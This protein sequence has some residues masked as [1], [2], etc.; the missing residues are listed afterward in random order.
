LY[1]ALTVSGLW[2][3]SSQLVDDL[4]SVRKSLEPQYPAIRRLAQLRTMRKA[5]GL[6]A[7]AVIMIGLEKGIVPDHSRNLA[8]EAR[9]FYVAM[10]RAREKLYLLH[11]WRRG[12]DVTW[13][14]K[15][16]PGRRRSCFLNDIGRPSDEIHNPGAILSYA[17]SGLE[18]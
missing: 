2:K 17:M 4:F 10:T 12:A 16:V 15:N 1:T 9:L 6:E 8:E 3:N 13:D 11:S 18:N 14:K 5:K 7:D